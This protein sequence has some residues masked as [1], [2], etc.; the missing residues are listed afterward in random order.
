MVVGFTQGERLTGPS[1]SSTNPALAIPA[2]DC[3]SSVIEPTLT[4]PFVI[5]HLEAA[6]GYLQLGMIQDANDELEE[7]A[8]AAK[9]SREVMVVRAVIYRQA[10]AWQLLREVGGFLVLNW[11]EEVQHWIWLAYGTRRCRSMEEG[12]QA[13]LDALRLHDR[14]PLIHFNL[15]CYASQLGNLVAARD[16]LAR[17]IKLDPN[18]RLMGLDDPDLEPLWAA[19]GKPTT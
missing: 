4:D 16:R 11:P 7:I 17:A 12:E 6:S 19:I 9:T 3:H 13:L 10:E 15:A 18:V 14:E 5:R 2:A 8:P 1:F